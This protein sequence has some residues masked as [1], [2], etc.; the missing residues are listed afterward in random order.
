MSSNQT[1]HTILSTSCSPTQINPLNCFNSTTR[2]YQSQLNIQKAK[3]AI[4]FDDST[5]ETKKI[6]STDKNLPMYSST[7]NGFQDSEKTGGFENKLM[8]NSVFLNHPIYEESSENSDREDRED[9]SIKKE[10]K[11]FKLEAQKNKSFLKKN[12]KRDSSALK[13]AKAQLEKLMELEK[14]LNL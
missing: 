14:K 7:I 3:K 9:E 11:D 1:P 2:E 13:I 4:F 8:N 12:K 10:I 6:Q 5:Y